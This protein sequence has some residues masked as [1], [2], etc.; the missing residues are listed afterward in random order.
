MDDAAFAHTQ[1]SNDFECSWAL[2]EKK[3][4]YGRK[5]MVLRY[6]RGTVLLM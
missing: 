5:T 3:T 6:N 1:L 4:P 2:V